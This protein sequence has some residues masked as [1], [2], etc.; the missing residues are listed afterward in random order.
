MTTIY[1][2]MCEEEFSGTML[3]GKA[4]FRKRFKWFA[5]NLDFVLDRVRDGKFNNSAQ[6]T[7]RYERIV[8]F[9][10]DLTKADWIRGNEIQFDVRRN[11]KIV[12]L[13][14]CRLSN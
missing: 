5:T 6:A 1:R 10:A 7:Q 14:E 3:Y 11:A 9:D 13:E 12:V 4:Q 8:S 2:A